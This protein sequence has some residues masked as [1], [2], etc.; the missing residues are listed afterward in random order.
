MLWFAEVH[1]ACHP[2]LQ[3][4]SKLWPAVFCTPEAEQRKALVLEGMRAVRPV[5]ETGYENVVQVR[6]L[7]EGVGVEEMLAHWHELLPQYMER[8]GLER[9]ALVDLF[10]ST[11]DQ[12]IAADLQGW[13]APNAI[14]PGVADALLAIMA[15]HEVYIVTTKQVGLCGR[16]K[17]ALVKHCS[18]KRARHGS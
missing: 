5:V 9:Q 12:W 1:E 14:Y 17:A 13:L 2:V 16:T 4:A 11:R 6:C 18:R 7:L 3:A 8:W 10:G 15:R